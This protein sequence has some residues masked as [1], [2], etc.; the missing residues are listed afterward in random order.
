MYENMVQALSLHLIKLWTRRET[1]CTQNGCESLRGNLDP[2][3]TIF[4]PNAKFATDPRTMVSI[5]IE[6]NGQPEVYVQAMQSVYYK[7]NALEPTPFN[8]V[9][10]H[11]FQRGLL[12]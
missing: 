6:I 4:P 2:E 5:H 3:G 10:N 12:L 7:N 1:T 9:I 8:R 11:P